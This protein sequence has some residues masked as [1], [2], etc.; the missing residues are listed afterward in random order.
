[1]RGRAF[2][3]ADREGAPP[4]ALVNEDLVRRYW[5][6]QQ[7]IGKR[8]RLADGGGFFEI[9][10]VAP[11]FEDADAPI[12][13]V[14]P[15]VYVPYAQARQFFGATKPATPPYQ[16]QLLVRAAGSPATLKTALRLEAAAADGSL[17]VRMQ[18]V[19]EMRQSRAGPLK[20]ISMLLSAL[21]GLALLMASVGLYA[22]LAYAV[23]QRTREIGIRMALGAQ[24]REILGLVMRR[25]AK[26]IACGIGAGLV[27]ALAVNRILMSQL[28]GIEGL[29][30]ATCIAVSLLLSAVAI[31]AGCLPAR[32]ALRVD[33]VRALRCE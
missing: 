21:G 33:P 22:V 13:S 14:R 25:T 30:A 32:K 17:Q 23:S 24:R 10:G 26:L 12:N 20:T 3:A 4:V 29:D 1:V 11:D 6:G 16:T 5:P 31:L 18:T 9:V 27:G 19:E 2:T 7:A 28:H 15:T 8:I